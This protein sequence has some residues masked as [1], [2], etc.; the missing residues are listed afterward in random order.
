MDIP[1]GAH[2]VTIGQGGNGS[3]PNYVAP[4]Q[5][6]TAQGCQGGDTSI[7]S[8]YVAAGGGWGGDYDMN[9]GNPGGSGGGAGGMAYADENTTNI[10]NKK[11]KPS[12]G[13]TLTSG[14][15]AITPA[16]ICSLQP[17][18]TAGINSLGIAPPTISFT[19]SS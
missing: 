5:A 7:G 15:P 2:T 13:N 16:S 11:G 8:I 10:N 1:K 3:R 4:V 14:Y 17:L 18:S 12:P 19:N 6:N 9:S